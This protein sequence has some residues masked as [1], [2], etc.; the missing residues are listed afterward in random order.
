MTPRHGS[1]GSKKKI[2]EFFLANIGR[3]IEKGELQ[4][5]SG[6][7][8]EW[9]R[10]IREL[11]DEDG[12]D[13]LSH[14]D[15]ADLKP[16]QYIMPSDKRRPSATRDISKET[17]ALVLDRDGY[18]CQSCGVAAADPDPLHPGRKV[19]LTMGHIID[20]SKGGSDTP[21]NLRAI[22]T[23][24]NEAAQNE[25]QPKPNRIALLAQIRRATIDDQ[26][27]VL[28]SLHGKYAGVRRMSDEE[29]AKADK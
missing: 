4:H 17:R 14:K 19:R 3:V 1:V 28:D 7:V 5:V 11:R 26:L 15:R 13:I 6:G 21:E 12:W 10:R 9:A 2:L 18:T 16:G 8:S 20:K 22:C 25:S 27:A 23:N 29:P 24:C